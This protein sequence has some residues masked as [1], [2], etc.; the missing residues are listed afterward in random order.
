MSYEFQRVKYDDLNSR[1]QENY[2]FQ[3]VAAHLADFGFNNIRLSDDWQGADFIACHV[4]GQTFLKVQLKSRLFIQKKYSGKD[5]YVAFIHRN[6]DK[7][8]DTYVYPHDVVRD[9]LL[10]RGEKTG[11]LTESKSWKVGGGYS[12]GHLSKGMKEFMQKY[13]V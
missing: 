12:W 4:D 8:E 5:I 3:K 7:T 9:E 11:T 2:N 1:Q 10:S 6:K 13:K